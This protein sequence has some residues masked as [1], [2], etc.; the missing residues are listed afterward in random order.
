MNIM[1]RKY[2]SVIAAVFLLATAGFSCSTDGAPPG[3]TTFAVSKTPE[4]S[5][6]GGATYTSPTPVVE[7][8][9]VDLSNT[10][11]ATSPEIYVPEPPPTGLP[12][13]RFSGLNYN[14]G[15]VTTLSRQAEDSLTAKQTVAWAQEYSQTF[16]DRAS[17][18]ADAIG[19]DGANLRAILEKLL[20]HFDPNDFYGKNG[21]DGGQII[22]MLSTRTV[23]I[24]LLIEK[25]KFEG[26][27]AWV[28]AL[29]WE[30]GRNPDSHLGHIAAIAYRYGSTEVLFAMS[31]A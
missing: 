27:D 11:E 13:V 4:I 14:R 6:P 8:I 18:Q 20:L 31:C 7:T 21:I 2:Y 29:N 24:P 17:A 28:M 5:Q 23:Q 15:D 16:I 22:F 10:P 26:K 25:A 19:L 30:M 1:R 3:T 12:V 9:T